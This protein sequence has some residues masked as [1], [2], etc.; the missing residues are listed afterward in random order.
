M[1][2]LSRIFR[3]T[4]Y[5]SHYESTVSLPLALCAIREYDCY[6]SF[7]VQIFNPDI[8][9]FNFIS[10]GTFGTFFHSFIPQSAYEVTGKIDVSAATLTMRQLDAK[11]FD[12][13][14]S[15]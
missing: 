2:I 4:L 14:S 12:D 6:L 8:L 11:Q 13:P 9:F 10:Q 3:E 15:S 7:E 1:C 5:K